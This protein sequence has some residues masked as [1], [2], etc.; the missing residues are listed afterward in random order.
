MRAMLPQYLQW[1]KAGS[2][3]MKPL[4]HFGHRSASLAATLLAALKRTSCPM[5]DAGLGAS[6]L[7]LASGMARNC[8]SELPEPMHAARVCLAGDGAL[9][10]EEV[11]VREHL[12]D[13]E[14]QLVRVELATE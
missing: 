12:A 7:G 9:G 1:R 13:G 8:T 3:S 10:L 14:G 4:L 6:G 5:G 2:R 11:Q